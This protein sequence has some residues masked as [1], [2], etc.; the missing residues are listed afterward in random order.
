MSDP[1][2]DIV[3]ETLTAA[4]EHWKRQTGLTWKPYF[5]HL[6]HYVVE[7][8][9]VTQPE[10]TR[11]YLLALAELHR[12]DHQREAYERARKIADV[13]ARELV[14]ALEDREPTKQ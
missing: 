14:D 4:N 5:V 6:L 1:A 12:P 2:E 11:E 9:A 13:R 8:L 3:R 7:W 10:P